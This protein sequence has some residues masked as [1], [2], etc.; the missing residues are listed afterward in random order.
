MAASD[1]EDDLFEEARQDLRSLP[2]GQKDLKMPESK[3]LFDEEE[4]SNK[5]LAKGIKETVVAE[6]NDDAEDNEEKLQKLLIS[7]LRI[8]GQLEN[9]NPGESGGTVSVK[10]MNKS[11]VE[12]DKIDCLED[13]DISKYIGDEEDDNKDNLFG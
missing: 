11:T 12:D 1:S 9:K 8:M 13:D 4:T 2:P 5:I 7:Q 3:E 6:G 10:V